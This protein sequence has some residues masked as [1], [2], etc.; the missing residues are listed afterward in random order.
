MRFSYNWLREFV[1]LKISARELADKL[2]MAGLEV[3]SVKP[4]GNDY[5]F[6]AEITPNRPDCLSVIGIAQEVA[7]IT[8]QKIK[9]KTKHQIKS[10]GEPLRF[11]I[12]IENKKDCPLYTA[13]IIRKVK[14]GPSPAWLKARLELIG[15]RSVNNI[16]DITNYIM[17]TWGEPLHAFDLD[18]LNS[19]RIIVRRARAA[20]K[21]ITIDGQQKTLDADILVIANRDNP[22]AIA[23]VMGGKDTE[24]TEDS[25]S[26]LLE[27][28]IFSPA[29]VRRGRRKLGLESESSYRF[30]R[31]VDLE[32][33]E[34]ASSECARLIQEF[35]QGRCVFS[36]SSARFK[37]KAKKIIL[38]IMRVQKTLGIDNINQA[39]IKK[40]LDNLGFKTKRR[41][42]NNLS[43]EIPSWRQDVALEADLIEE[44]TR[45]LG[46]EKI[47]TTLPAIIPPGSL[48]RRR[49]LVLKTKTILAGLGLDEVI[50][51]SLISQELLKS[52][53]GQQAEPIEIANPLSK[54][55]E[56]L[57]PSL[58]PSLL[59]CVSYNLN[60]KENYVNIFEIASGFLKSDDSRLGEELLL[61][62]ALCGS[63]T[64]FLQPGLVKD[65]VGFLNLK[66]VLETLF[67]CLGI[68]DYN[69]KV[70]N[71]D[72][73]SVYIRQE[74]IGTML[75]PQT[76]VLDSLDI[77]NKK[78]VLLELSL[79]KVF[80]YANLA[81]KFTP[82]PIYPA[83][84][85]DV[86]FILKDE[87]PV[88]E[89]IKNIKEKGEP[90]LRQVKIV[91]YY[92]GK[93]IASG[94]K[95]LTVSCIYRSDQRT[96]TEA[97]I[98]PIHAG[99]VEM[100]KDKFRAQIR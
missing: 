28:A 90:L 42:K 35:A 66:G 98:N 63:K 17:F 4:E 74:K 61:G 59:K 83:I 54:E 13:K 37:V 69:F 58:I 36:K 88:E 75:S 72:R 3:G 46:Y 5:V 44:I 53:M 8:G 73:I 27:A 85:R 48:S 19:D 33:A 41:G 81:R 76:S 24:V 71:S 64:Y 25:Q 68:K 65:E 23:G 70:Q 97:E 49:E 87:L 21:L 67:E 16:V 55:Q 31:G 100:L 91:D 89:V 51:Y 30:E 79:D 62:I 12:E 77:K 99:I 86:S 9:L 29:L 93:Q 47:P 82:L 56:I 15:C 84:S 96:L 57:R 10:Q 45:I 6:E 1:N 32:K 40:I 80:A 38:D 78:A 14:V 34:L 39:K 52:Q 20:E 2:T 11:A 43:V 60:Q 18:K 95:G 7:A 50:T 94:S 22:V 26:V 92:K